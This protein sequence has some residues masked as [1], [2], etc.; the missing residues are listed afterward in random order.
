MAD[1]GSYWVRH[2]KG[3]YIQVWGRVERSSEIRKNP[4]RPHYSRV[5]TCRPHWDMLA[6]RGGGSRGTW[7]SLDLCRGCN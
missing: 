1:Y 6:A 3:E 5:P 2:V 7:R 4:P